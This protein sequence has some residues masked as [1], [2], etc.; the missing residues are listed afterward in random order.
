[1]SAQPAEQPYNPYRL[2]A[3]Q[4]PQTLAELRAALAEASPADLTRF[5]AKLA[6]ARLDQVPDVIAEYRHVWALRTRPE[7]RAALAAALAGTA[8]LVTYPVGEGTAA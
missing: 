7:A 5:D 8:E 3:G 1:M 6:G 4:G 2:E